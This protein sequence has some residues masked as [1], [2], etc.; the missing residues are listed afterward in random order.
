VDEKWFNILVQRH[1]TIKEDVYGV[2]PQ[3][4]RSPDSVAG[5]I[6]KLLDGGSVVRFAASQKLHP[7]ERPR[8]VLEPT[9]PPVPWLAEDILRGKTAGA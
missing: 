8:P 9:K 7:S 4:L 2:E 6:T 1:E 5:I 3:A